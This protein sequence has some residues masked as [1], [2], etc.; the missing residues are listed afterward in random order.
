MAGNELL[1]CKRAERIQRAIDACIRPRLGL[2]RPVFTRHAAADVL[3]GVS[4]KTNAHRQ[5]YR[6]RRSDG[7]RWAFK[8]RG[9]GFWT[10]GILRTFNTEVRAVVLLVEARVAREAA[11]P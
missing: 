7:V 9:S 10:V 2:V 6:L 11:D 3:L 4:R 8:G 5:F 1:S